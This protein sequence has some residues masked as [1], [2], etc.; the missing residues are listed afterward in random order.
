MGD[1]ARAIGNA[2]EKETL[3][4]RTLDL[5]GPESLTYREMLETV[6]RLQKRNP[7]F[8]NVPQAPLRVVTKMLER[9][10][11]YPVSADQLAMMD[12]DAV[13]SEDYLNYYSASL[14]SYEE[15][16]KE[17]TKERNTN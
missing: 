13:K 1:L 4:R 11:F 9:F 12:E 7:G 2:L 3:S 5:E 15:G 8:L 16:I 10:S 6:A 14:K 17:T